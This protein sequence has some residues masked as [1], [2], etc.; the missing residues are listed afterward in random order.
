[1]KIKIISIQI[2][3]LSSF[4]FCQSEKVIELL[5]EI[6]SGSLKSSIEYLKENSSK[7]SS[8]PDIFYLDA[9][10]TEDGKTA[11]DKYSAF[12]E[13]F[14]DHYFADAA[15]FNIYSYYYSTGL[16][17]KAN[18]WFAKL[19][20]EFPRSKYIPLAKKIE[21]PSSGEND[22]AAA[23]L[24]EG[25]NENAVP[26]PENTDNGLT[27]Y[28][29]TVQAGAF[30]NKFNAEKL[31]ADLKK[32]KYDAVITEKNVGGSIFNIVTTGKFRTEQE[33]EELVKK[34]NEK[35]KIS[36]RVTEITQ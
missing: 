11:L 2:I 28:K 14:P 35:L 36:A 13:K 17:V 20:S 10:L 8:D 19:E 3:F 27:A 4:I 21:S 5:E 23:E 7:V 6:E 32:E 16:Y 1:M 31:K 30:I 9:V 34:I 29:F 15:M 18:E 12:L 33:A 25:N 22:N 26:V 24:P